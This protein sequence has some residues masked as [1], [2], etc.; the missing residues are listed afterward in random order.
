[1]TDNTAAVL[2]DGSAFATASFPLPADHWLYQANADGLT[3]PPPMSFRMIACEHRTLF[4][5]KLRV[6]TQWALRAATRCGKE[7]DLDPDALV[8][9]VILGMLG[10]HTETGLC[11]EAWADPDPVPPTHGWHSHEGQANNGPG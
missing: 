8:Q 9:N 10:Y 3:G 11:G 2:P 7:G 1:M 4:E 5:E 6:A